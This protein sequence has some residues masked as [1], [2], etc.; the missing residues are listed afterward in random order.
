MTYAILSDVHANLEALSA[1]LEDLERHPIKKVYFLGDAV[2]YGADPVACLKLIE[3]ISDVQIAGNHDFMAATISASENTGRKEVSPIRWTGSRLNIRTKEKLVGLNLDVEDHLTHSFHG[4]PVRPD[5]WHYIITSKDAERGFAE[6]KAKLIF[7]GHSHVPSCFIETEH[8][9]FFGGETRKVKALK[10]DMV[11][12]KKPYRYIINVG[13]VGQPRDNNSRAAYGIYD[14]DA[15]TF[16][17]Y[18][19][20]Y[21][22]EKAAKKIR[23][24]GLP[25]EM[26]ERLRWGR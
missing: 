15:N 16:T 23:A 8:K 7:V 19:V 4:S 26:A 20:K 6:N 3:E 12:F 24:A 10:P 25:D 5:E 22:I 2:G 13:S 14:P 18:R 21:D 11:S 9:R 1:V 17:L